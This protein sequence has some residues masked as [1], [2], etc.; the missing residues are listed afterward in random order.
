M[1]IITIKSE[2]ENP[3]YT[4]LGNRINKNSKWEFQIMVSMLVVKEKKKKKK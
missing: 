4:I 1:F 2:A 3:F